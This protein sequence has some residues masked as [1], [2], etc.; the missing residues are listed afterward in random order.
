VWFG[1]VLLTFPMAPVTFFA[2]PVIMWMSLRWF[3]DAVAA[4]RA[5]TA[6]VRLLRVGKP[7]L[8]ALREK[9][10]ELYNRVMQLARE[11]DLPDEPEVYFR[12]SGGR[13]KGRI[14][15]RW[16]SNVRY[17]SLKRRRKRDWNEILRLYDKVD[18]PAED[19]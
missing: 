16:D 14:M 10:G 8:T 5:F 15:G 18:F 7:T 3:E 11:L 2:I 1:A 17:F 13:E 4:F 9:R 12:T 19:Y 6:L